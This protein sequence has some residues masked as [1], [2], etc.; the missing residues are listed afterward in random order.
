MQQTLGDLKYQFGK[1]RQY[2]LLDS[3]LISTYIFI[4]YKTIEDWLRMVIYWI[5]EYTFVARIILYTV[6]PMKFDS[7]SRYESLMQKEWR[8]FIDLLT[9]R[10]IANRTNF[11]NCY[12]CAKNRTNILAAH[13][14]FRL[15]NHLEFYTCLGSKTNL[16]FCSKSTIAANAVVKF[17]AI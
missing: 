4:N 9:N 2:Y 15:S 8:Y 5:S 14:L 7:M 6:H 1:F 17:V 3:L 12:L 10:S 13:L 16:N 11:D